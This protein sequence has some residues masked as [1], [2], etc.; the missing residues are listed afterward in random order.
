MSTGLDINEF[1]DF[2]GHNGRQFTFHQRLEIDGLQ[3]AEDV[4]E[5][6]RGGSVDDGI[7]GE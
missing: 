2:R 4:Y 5:R 7:V 3:D 6:G 1:A